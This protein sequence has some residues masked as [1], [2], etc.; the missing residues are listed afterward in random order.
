MNQ[1]Q[2][3]ELVRGEYTRAAIQAKPSG[4]SCSEQIHLARKPLA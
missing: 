3:K 4:S 1:R 2:I